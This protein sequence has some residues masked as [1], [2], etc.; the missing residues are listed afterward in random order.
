MAAQSGTSAV[1]SV[2]LFERGNALLERLQ[3][4][5]DVSGGLSTQYT[6]A[7]KK[8]NKLSE[9]LLASQAELAELLSVLLEFLAELTK[10]AKRVVCRFFHRRDPGL[11]AMKHNPSHSSN[12]V[13]TRPP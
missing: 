11:T 2:L 1:S 4:A 6:F 8:T 10:K 7:R 3:P 9:S 13:R 12:K 5:V